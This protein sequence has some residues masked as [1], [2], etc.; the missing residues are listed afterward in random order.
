MCAP[1]TNN[2]GECPDGPFDQN[3]KIE[4]FRGCTI[5]NQATDCPA[6]GD[7]CQPKKRECYTDNGVVGGTVSAAGQASPPVNNVSRPLLSALFCIGPTGTT[8]V[9]NAAGLPGLGRLTLR[10]TARNLFE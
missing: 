6:P 2:E 8:A 9:D 4:S 3:C 5:P 10:A 1:T 7:S